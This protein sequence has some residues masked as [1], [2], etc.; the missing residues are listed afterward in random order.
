MPL[1]S[2]S[3]LGLSDDIV[4]ALKT[5]GYE[6]PTSIQAQAIPLILEGKDILG[7]SQT[8]TGKTAAFCLPIL[9]KIKDQP[10]T[11]NPRA[12]IITPT[13][14]LA[15]QITSFLDDYG[16]HLN[17]SY[18]SVVGGS[19][20]RHQIKEIK[21]GI[22]ILVATPG[23]L[24]DLYGQKIV[25]FD[26]IKYV[27]LDE[28]D[29]MLDMGFIPDVRKIMNKLPKTN[30]QTLFFSATFNAEID[31][32]SRE[33]LKD[34]E[35]IEVALRMATADK[36]V[37]VIHPVDFQH[38]EGLLEHLL[39]TKEGMDHVLVFTKTKRGADQV[40]R[41]LLRHGHDVEVIHG[42]LNQNARTRALEKFRDHEVPIL[43]ATDIASR[44][45]DVSGI[46]HVI[47]FDVPDTVE[48]YVHRIGRTARADAEGDAVTLV[49]GME[50]DII[51]KIEEETGVTIPRVEVEG[52]EPK[53]LRSLGRL[54]EETVDRNNPKIVTPR[55]RSSG[56]RRW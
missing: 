43:I 27:V 26:D 35:R 53:T 30:R 31:R 38:K 14:E 28:A 21:G 48:D 25:H 29:R 17:L 54:D 15:A 51:K 6:E 50:W 13:R 37:Q 24:L 33:F 39:E 10:K 9:Q 49:S 34:P 3:T 32:L 7:S 36:V 23:R 8:G 55:M 20:M 5:R 12:L 4:K 19:S 18:L 47:N 44:G 41:Y 46:T 2:F 22:D 11:D 52:F 1:Q 16:T 42:D 40:T 45:I 56:R